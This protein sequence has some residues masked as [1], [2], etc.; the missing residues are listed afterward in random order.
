MSRRLQEII[1]F[2]QEIDKLKNVERQVNTSGGRPESSAEH[3]WHLCMGLWLLKDELGI[4]FNLE[5]AFKMALVHDL[6]EIHAGDTFFFDDAAQA[7]KRAREEEAAIKLFAQLPVELSA[8]LKS[9]WHEYE[10]KSSPEARVVGAID[11]LM[12]VIQNILSE[13]SGWKKH[14]LNYDRIMQKKEQYLAGLSGL[15]IVWQITQDLMAEAKEK[16]YC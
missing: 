12:P 2:L 1:D 15:D 16:N 10:A 11:K 6:V 14:N 13:G 4:P 5:R 7:H 8:E 9:L 3:T